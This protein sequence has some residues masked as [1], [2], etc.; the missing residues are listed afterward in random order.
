MKFNK[1]GELV[2]DL[3]EVKDHMTDEQKRDFVGMLIYERWFM[4]DIAE[5][6][7]EGTLKEGEWYTY[8]EM[9]QEA[10]MA[11]VQC[12]DET[13][14]KLVA[15]L[16]QEKEKA[17]KAAEFYRALNWEI[18]RMW[19][20]DSNLRNSSHEDNY[21]PYVTERNK[22]QIKKY[23]DSRIKHFESGEKDER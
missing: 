18:H 13:M 9:F 14:Q 5:I 4:K 10:R 3:Y 23:I 6:M 2:I 17:V 12:Q 15:V 8:P 7:T 22:F 16:V 1:E 11:L 19:D 21:P 20:T